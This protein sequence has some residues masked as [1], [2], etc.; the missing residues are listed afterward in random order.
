MH[1]QNVYT[2][3][4]DIFLDA[5][6]LIHEHFQDVLYALVGG[7]AVQIYVSAAAIHAGQ[8]QSV[9]DINGLA[10]ILRKTGDLDLSFHVDAAELVAKFNLIIEQA[11]GTYTFHNFP[12]RFVLQAGPRRFNLNYQIEPEDLK[13][14]STYYH[15]I[16]ATAIT[17]VLPYQH[18]LLQLKLARPEYLIVS[19]LTRAKPKDQID[20]ALLLKAMETERY[21]FDAEEVRSILK[22]VN[23]GEQYDLLAELMESQG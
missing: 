17:V 7:G 21:A 12:K 22:A 4:D 18:T 23:K 1:K 10:F 5:L 13:G 9:K 11:S 20:I 15:D 2:I 3:Q 19:K 8:L 14:I 16:I 6:K